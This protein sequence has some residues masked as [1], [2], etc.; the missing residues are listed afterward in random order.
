MLEFGIDLIPELIFGVFEDGAAYL[1]KD[2]D[3]K[4]LCE[5][6]KSICMA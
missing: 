2:G 6:G 4:Q 3:I 5:K 1:I